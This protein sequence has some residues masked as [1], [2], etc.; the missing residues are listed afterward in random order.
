MEK[1][2]T[3]DTPQVRLAFRTSY[4]GDHFRGSQMQADAR[5]VE[6]E[7]VAACIRC[8]LFDDY[9]RAGFLS[10]GRTDRGVHSRGQIV[11]F[12][13]DAPERAVSALNWQLPPDCFVTGVARV[14]P[15]FHPRYDAKSRTY[16][17]YFG[18][19]D[20]DASAMDRAARHFCG[21]HNF[22]LFA[23]VRDKNPIRTVISSSVSEKEGFYF[24][25]V[26]AE[27]FLWH[28]V[29]YMASAL[30]LIGAGEK[31]EGFISDRLSGD[32]QGP[33]SPAQPGGL[34]LWDVDCGISF[35]HVK[36]DR[37]TGD[38]LQEQQAHHAV[39]GMVCRTLGN[40][41]A[42]ADT[43]SGKKNPEKMD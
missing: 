1:I 17:Y 39:M 19:R 5:T 13:T 8:R 28:M 15:E 2:Q 40:D 29:R 22:S 42:L 25:E 7:F 9:H 10:A 24:F 33:L 38:Y 37:R 30:I 12:T 18:R 11:A 32:E 21:T 20:L 4:L 23:R 3:P 41:V 16:R 31:D 6:G 43:S 14:P 35:V 34:I 27:S 36:T 26:T